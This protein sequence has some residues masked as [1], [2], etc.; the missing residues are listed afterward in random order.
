MVSGVLHVLC[1]LF[2]VAYFERAKLRQRVHDR[3]GNR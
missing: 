2:R 1:G 3:C